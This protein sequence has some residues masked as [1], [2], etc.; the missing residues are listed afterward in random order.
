MNYWGIKLRRFTL[1]Y[2][3]A[4]VL[5]CAVSAT[6]APRHGVAMHGE[7]AL[8]PDFTHFAY[9]DPAAPKGGTLVLGERGAFDNLNPFTVRGVVPLGIRE[10]VFESLLKRSND[11]A[12]SL[13]GWVAQSV[14]V[15]GDRSWVSFTLDPRARFSNGAPIRVEDVIFSAE[16]LRE[17][18]RP[19]HRSYYAKITHISQPGPGQVRFDFDPK[20][21]DREMPLILG[22]MPILSKAHYAGLDISAPSLRPPLGSG[23]YAVGDVTPG[24]SISYVRNRDY[25]AADLPVNRGQ[26]N[27]DVIRVDF[28][29]DENTAFEAFKAGQFD[30]WEEKDPARWARAY[31]F[32]AVRD[33]AVAR[34]AI[35]HGRP[36]G[37]P[38]FVFNTRRAP[39]DDI[40][41]RQAL[42]FMFD[43]E[44]VN[45]SFFHGAYRRTRSLFDNTALAAAENAA[46]PEERAL[47]A[48]YADTIAKT[49]LERGYRPPVSDGS[50][51]NRE[52]AK[53][54]RALLADAGWALKD[55]LMVQMQTGAPLQFEILLV[56]PEEEKL[57]LVFARALLRLGIKI[58]VRTV[59][60]SQYE[61][62]LRNY[63]FDMI[64]YD[65]YASLSPGN[66]QKYYWGSAA[67]DTP[68]AR[69]YPGVKSAAMDA[70]INHVLEAR[71]EAEFIPAVRAMDRV[72]MSGH[73]VIPLYYLPAD[74][75]AHRAHLGFPDRVPLYGFDITS[76]WDGRIQRAED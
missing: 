20:T 34:A 33:G 41:V 56:R 53:R 73:Y 74:N 19:N 57:A 48:P 16:T 9:A 62:R 45:R 32:R 47:L 13:Y 52:G 31:N 76:W 44:W 50:G 69:N 36:S 21:I 14:E 27:F 63:D 71:T 15:A 12:F 60:A 4:A 58:N 46:G 65:W 22:L 75:V 30:L 8:G 70:M 2:L 26:N 61:E 28:Y 29:R 42:N 25:W 55:G 6:A 68:G 59:D 37:L 72:L 5:A 3:L 17:K 24:R 49:V 10:W 39:F 43:F 1:V 67:A 38:G 40:R 64:V 35:P 51:H 11:E 54:A 7:V 66:E 18:G 23:P